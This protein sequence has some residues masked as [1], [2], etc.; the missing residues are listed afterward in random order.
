MVCNG[1]DLTPNLSIQEALQHKHTQ[2][3]TI[4]TVEQLAHISLKKEDFCSVD[5][6]GHSSKASCLHFIST[7]KNIMALQKYTFTGACTATPWHTRQLKKT[8][9]RIPNVWLQIKAHL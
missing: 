4:S 1:L 8:T 2:T 6:G 7:F 3:R 9:R 5:G